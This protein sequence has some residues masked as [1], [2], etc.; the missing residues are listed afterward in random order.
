VHDLDPAHL[1]TIGTKDKYIV[2]LGEEVLTIMS[3]C[4]ATSDLIA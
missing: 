2:I 4:M 3:E 1:I